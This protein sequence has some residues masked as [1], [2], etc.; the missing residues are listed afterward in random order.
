[1][2]SFVPSCQLGQWRL[3]L[4]PIKRVDTQGGKFILTPI[5]RDRSEGPPCDVTE[6]H[7]KYLREERR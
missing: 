6:M 2:S 3:W 1:M 5:M 4:P 7:E